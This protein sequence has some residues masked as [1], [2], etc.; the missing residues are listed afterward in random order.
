M[1]TSYH[2]TYGFGSKIEDYI[3]ITSKYSINNPEHEFPTISRG[4]TNA[5]AIF[6]HLLLTVQLI[7]FE[8]TNLTQFM[9]KLTMN[10]FV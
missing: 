10:P 3:N 4:L 7:L 5:S 2:I 8:N 9:N 1:F 6:T